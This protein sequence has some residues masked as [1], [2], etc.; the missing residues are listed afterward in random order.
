MNTFCCHNNDDPDE[1]WNTGWCVTV[2]SRTIKKKANTLV[3]SMHPAPL[4]CYNPCVNSC[5]C[6]AGVGGGVCACQGVGGNCVY[7]AFVT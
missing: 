1:G 5:P 7:A 4:L 2:K 3:F 6:I